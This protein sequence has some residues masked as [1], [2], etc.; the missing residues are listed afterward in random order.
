MKFS[1]AAIAKRFARYID[2]IVSPDF[3]FIERDRLYSIA[4]HDVIGK[5]I[6]DYNIDCVFD[7]GANVGQYAQMLRHNVGYR[8]L[9]ISFEAIP[10]CASELRRIAQNDQRWIIEEVAVS[11]EAGELDFNVMECAEFSSL[12]V[13][14]TDAFDLTRDG[15]EVVSV[16]KVKADTL[17]HFLHFY[18][19]KLGFSRPLL[20]MD[21]QGHDVRIARAA[22]D[23]LD[24]FVALQSELAIVPI[25]KNA[26]LM[27]EALQFYQERGF[28]LS[29]LVPNNA[30]H[31]PHL[32]EIDC[33]M[34]NKRFLESREAA[35]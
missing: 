7:I 28:I 17:Q 23:V 33:V 5:I 18:Q 13:P 10:D 3:R 27:S 6:F 30:G 24:Q 19:N 21:T 8:G 4:E 35:E 32:I 31:F 34:L 9:I 1:S 20:K 12:S 16:V 26:P 14:R 11:D 29:A 22:S 2:K 25:Y 15:N